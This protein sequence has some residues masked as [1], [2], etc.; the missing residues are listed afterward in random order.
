MHR[1]TPTSKPVATSRACAALQ[2]C[3][4]LPSVT[5]SDGKHPVVTVSYRHWRVFGD[6]QEK[7]SARAIGA[8]VENRQLTW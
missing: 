5:V 2:L 8:V 3:R 7:I 1:K 4:Q 6:C